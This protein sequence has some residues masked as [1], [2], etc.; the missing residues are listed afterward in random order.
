LINNVS[1]QKANIFNDVKMIPFPEVI[2]SFYGLEP[3]RAGKIICPFHN[4]QT[5]SFQIY[6]DSGYCFGCTWAG[7]S[8]AFIAQ[9]ENI[10]PIEAARL[11]AKQFNLPVDRPPTVYGQNKMHNLKRKQNLTKAYYALEQKAFVNMVNFRSLVLRIIEV[12]GLDGLGPETVKAA[13]MLPVIE[14]QMMT[15]AIGSNEERLQLLR[16]GVLSK[17]ADLE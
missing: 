9:L 10:R 13:H 15:L 16:E 6:E 14:D 4:E 2:R 5:A 7:D 3:N 11:I 17:W 1:L 8:V 12:C